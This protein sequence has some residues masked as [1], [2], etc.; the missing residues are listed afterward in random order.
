MNFLNNEKYLLNLLE[1]KKLITQ[2]QRKKILLNKDEQLKIL[3]RRQGGRR[4][5]NGKAQVDAPFDLLESILSFNFEIPNTEARVL[6]EEIIMRAVA[7]DQKMTFKKL[8]PL[9]LDLEI[10]TKSIPKS[11]AFKHL[12]LPFDIKNGVLQVAI[13]EPG[14]RAALDEIERANQDKVKPFISTRSDIRRMLAEFF[15]FQKSISAA[16]T[17]MA[18]PSVDLGNLEQYVQIS[19]SK[20]IASSDQHIKSA[21]DHLF[22]YAFE[23]RASDIHIEPKRNLSA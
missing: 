21:V 14:N 5:G 4:V 18:G 9:D 16:E 22:N 3:R 17:H 6:T 1:K 12:L 2:E 15:G 10:V 13:C 23:Q 8:D 20:E 19:S 11:F 7:A